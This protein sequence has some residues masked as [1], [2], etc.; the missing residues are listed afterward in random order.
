MKTSRK[1]WNFVKKRLV[2]IHKR[3]FE[4]WKPKWVEAELLPKVIEKVSL[5]CK[6]NE[7]KAKLVE[8][9]VGNDITL[10]YTTFW[11]V[12]LKKKK[13]AV[14]EEGSQVTKEIFAIYLE[15]ASYDDCIK[16]NNLYGPD[17][18]RETDSLTTVLKKYYQDD[19]LF[20]TI[21]IPGDRE[22]ILGELSMEDYYI[23]LSYIDHKELKNR[24]SLIQ[25]EQEAAAR[26]ISRSAFNKRWIGTDYLNTDILESNQRIIIIGNPGIGKSTYA[27]WFCYQWAAGKLTIPY[28]PL[29]IQLRGVDFSKDATCLLQY[30][31][32]TYFPN[33]AVE[34]LKLVI[35]QQFDS[36]L[37][38]FDGFDELAQDAK[39]KFE[40]ELLALTQ[41]RGRARYILL[42]RPYGLL[43]RRFNQDLLLELDGF[44]ESSIENYIRKFLKQNTNPNKSKQGLL[45][46]IKKNPILKEYA[47]NPLMLS[48]I[49]LIYVTDDHPVPFL[50]GIESQYDLQLRVFRWIKDYAAAHPLA[51][52]SGELKLDTAKALAYELMLQ[53]QFNYQSAHTDF[54]F[55]KEVAIYLNQI[56]LGTILTDAKTMDWKFGFN[57]VSFQEFLAADFYQPRLTVPAF[58]YLLQDHFFWNFAKLLLGAL[59]KKGKTK[60]IIEI[61]DLLQA[62]YDT[63]DK[64][65]LKFLYFSLLSETSRSFIQLRLQSED[66]ETLLAFYQD[67][68]FDPY[69]KSIIQESLQRIYYK[70]SPLLKRQFHDL[71]CTK[72][73]ALQKA[74]H[75]VRGG[76]MPAY[77]LF[78]LGNLTEVVSYKPFVKS[79]FDTTEQLFEQSYQLQ[80]QIEELE[81]EDK[82][83]LY[84]KVS[85]LNKLDIE[86]NNTTFI[87]FQIL[88][89]VP[90]TVLRSFSKRIM[91]LRKKG[92]LDVYMDVEKLVAK[93]QSKEDNIVELLENIK[94]CSLLP[95]SDIGY[96]SISD[97]YA[98]QPEKAENEEAGK[99]VIETLP[100]AKKIFPKE[101]LQLAASIFKIGYSETT[102]ELPILEEAV[103]LYL[104]KVLHPSYFFVNEVKES[105]ELI[106]SGLDYLN[107]PAVWDLLFEFIHRMDNDMSFDIE[108]DEAFKKY[109]QQRLEAL[110]INFDQQHFDTL[111][112]ALKNT[113][114]GKYG[115]LQFREN[116]NNLVFDQ[117]NQN[118]R[119]FA[120]PDY[121]TLIEDL[122]SPCHD[123][124]EKILQVPHFAYDKKFFIDKIMDSGL[125]YPYIRDYALPYL[126]EDE[127]PFFQDKY[128]AY[129]D[130]HY[131]SQFGI[132]I[133]TI[134]LLFNDGIYWYS[135]NLAH[136][137]KILAHCGKVVET[138]TAEN[139]EEIELELHSYAHHLLYIISNTLKLLKESPPT[140][141]ETHLL[142]STG[143]LL[144]RPELQKIYTE[145]GYLEAF[146]ANDLLAYILQ[147]AYTQDPVFTLPIPYQELKIGYPNE[148]RTLLITLI[149]LFTNQQGMVQHHE[150]K[151]LEPVLG[152]SFYKDVQAYI[153]HY[154]VLF[155][156]FDRATFEDLNS[157][158]VA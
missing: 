108:N 125:T 2:V 135:S 14:L 86:V 101:L 104:R 7:A 5:I 71:L 13:G 140:A 9:E 127:F 6:S 34:E 66:L 145:K 100:K 113:W 26:K 89:A 62:S 83:E 51:T 24:A 52:A 27:R 23:A 119:L 21:R 117:F 32:Q 68:Y 30:L 76:A 96:Y 154:K 67:A 131:S 134:D 48:Y 70:L 79:M 112:P 92:N 105:T 99:L 153:E 61:F 25:K 116:L 8:I 18:Q 39:T 45:K 56:G 136:L 54:Q 139:Q 107:K 28:V 109:I 97:L 36:Y 20:N 122:N 78:D 147:F 149:E 46:I 11:R 158:K 31:H 3:P 69:W 49:V 138:M 146:D 144:T 103:R 93:L 156:Q 143:I 40:Q 38:L 44:T 80:K 1:F 111:V 74:K 148:H 90:A 94:K 47:Y 115:F 81:E 22:G 110:Q 17:D 75:Q 157:S 77:T 16:E 4:K 35:Q 95:D 123:I 121:E 19:F 60:T 57:T 37:F 129:F 64:N 91:T 88:I 85:A 126:F 43:H 87:I 133:H 137:Y 130:K 82:K 106:I 84:D 120:S 29:Y 59:S 102:I 63:A 98:E 65:Y 141:F 41:P 152:Q 142:Q 155:F 12:L 15:Y 114:N 118:Q 128:W 42:S 151:A 72:M 58:I 33:T 73:E 124:L 10:S 150:L 55:S 50:E 53:R 132:P